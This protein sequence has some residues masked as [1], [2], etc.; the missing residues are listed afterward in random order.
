M[1][2]LGRSDAG[3]LATL[4]APYL[5]ADTEPDDSEDELD[6]ADVVVE[7]EVVRL[8]RALGLPVPEDLLEVE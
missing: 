6:D 8:L 5:A 2:V 3:E 7:D 1:A 4:I